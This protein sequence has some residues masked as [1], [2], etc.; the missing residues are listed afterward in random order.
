MMDPP[1]AGGPVNSLSTMYVEVDGKPSKE[2][3][4][5]LTYREV[6]SH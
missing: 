2:W 5:Q 4:H 3:A 1:Q 6:L